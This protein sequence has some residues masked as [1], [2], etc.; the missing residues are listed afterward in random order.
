MTSK[1]TPTDWTFNVDACID[2]MIF[3][4]APRLDS[5]ISS[6]GQ[7]VRQISQKA[8]ECL[9]LSHFSL[10]FV[11]GRGGGHLDP[12]VFECFPVGMSVRNFHLMCYLK[13]G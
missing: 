8:K 4:D 7:T 13:Q 9:F 11:H 3:M 5:R 1:L 12:T 10:A 2:G 6:K